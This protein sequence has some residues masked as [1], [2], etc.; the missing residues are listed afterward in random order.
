MQSSLKRTNLSIPVDVFRKGR[1]RAITEGSSLSAVVTALLRMW[2]DGEVEIP[3]ER[4]QAGIRSRKKGK[5]I[6]E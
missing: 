2:L 3:S 6:E 1:G 4:L 5:S